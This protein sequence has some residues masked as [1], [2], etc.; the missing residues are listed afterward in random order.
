MS[1]LI[2]KIAQYG[3]VE[4]KARRARAV[5]EVAGGAVTGTFIGSVLG[6][7]TKA[8]LIG[9]GLGALYGA[10]AEAMTR[11][12]ENEQ[13]QQIARWAGHWTPGDN[14]PEPFTTAS[15]GSATKGHGSMKAMKTMRS[16]A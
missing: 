2:E 10:A 1:M 11:G 13:K 16:T 7:T 8:A 14:S 12:V 4:R 3:P 15:H 5:R 9:A 6:K